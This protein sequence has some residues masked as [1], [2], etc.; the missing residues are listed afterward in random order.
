MSPT[1]EALGSYLS[2]RWVRGEGVET[3]LVDPVKG[4]ELATASAKGVD[5]KDALAFARR[6]GQGGLRSLG[7]GERAKLVGTVAD[8]LAANR[9]RYEEIAIANSGNTKTDAAIDIDGG[10]GTLKYYARLGAGLGAARA[11]LDEKP[12]RLAKAENYQAIHLM[13]PRRGV[14]VHINAFNFPSWGLWEKAAVSLLA[15]VPVVAKPAS[16]TALLAHAMVRDVIAARVLPDGALSLLCGGAGG[17]LEALASEDVV[18]FTGS[19]DTARRVR[20]HPNVVAKSVPV[21]IEADSINA[22][23]LAPGCASGSAAFD[24]FVREV[25]REMTVKAGQKCTAIRRVFAQPQVAGAVADALAAKLKGTKV[26]DPRAADTRMGPVVTRA[27]QA[28]AFEG[29]RRLASEA[30]IVCGGAEPPAL[31]GIDAGRSAF[32]APTLLRLNDAGTA[33]AVHE[34]EV[35]GP[36]ATVVPYRD[37]ADAVALIARGGGSLV[38]SVYGDDADFLARIVS[39]IGPGHGRLLMVDPSIASAHT[40]HGIVM[41]QCNH[42]GPGRAGAGEELGGLHGLRFY[43]Q[44][45]AVQGSTDL[46]ATLQAQAASLH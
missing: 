42:G 35:F 1:P 33:T 25:V 14:A 37:E 19:A 46:L 41:P 21:N 28:A 36:A 10:I 26:G 31:D 15:G 3:R 44:R 4:E 7:Y 6:E 22:A 11:L 16:A 32:V 18:A 24:A 9:A 38:A 30:A 2:G 34:V 5:L 23:L 40:G 27:Q 39:A 13:V 8:V 20:G 45:L 17:L 12:V 43:H 29:I